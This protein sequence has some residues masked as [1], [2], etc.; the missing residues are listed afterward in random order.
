MRT[1][2]LALL[3]SALLASGVVAQQGSAQVKVPAAAA[4]R[5]ATPSQSPFKLVATVQQVMTTIT[6]PASD[7]IFNAAAEAPKNEAAWQSLQNSALALAESGNLLM[8][9]GRAKDNKEWVKESQAMIAAATVAFNAARDRNTDRVM[10]ASDRIYVT[11]EACHDK[12]MD[13]SR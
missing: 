12:Y 4:R 11:C 1:I 3:T 8:I 10:K 6:I 2:L 7:V 5:V 13:K 9:P